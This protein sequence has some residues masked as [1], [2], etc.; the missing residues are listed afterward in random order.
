MYVRFNFSLP[1]QSDTS[2]CNITFLA[3]ENSEFPSVSRGMS[4]ADAIVSR[5]PTAHYRSRL[6]KNAARCAYTSRVSSDNPPWSRIA[7]FPDEFAYFVC[8]P[9]VSVTINHIWICV[10]LRETHPQKTRANPRGK[11]RNRNNQR[12]FHRD[13]KF[14]ERKARSLSVSSRT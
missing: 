2:E 8:I 12:H 13:R 4:S 11:P 7:K 14:Q 1:L 10:R 9:K 6:S 3:R 5:P